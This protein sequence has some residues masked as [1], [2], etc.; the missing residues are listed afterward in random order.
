MKLPPREK[1]ALSGAGRR[2]LLWLA[3][4]SVL[5]Y[6]V[7]RTLIFLA[8]RSE[9]AFPSFIVMVVYAVLLLGFVLAYLIYNRFLYRKNVTIEQLPDDWTLEQKQA[10]LADGEERLAKS[11]WMMTI[12]FPL[13]L[14]FFL[15]ALDLFIFDFFK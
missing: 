12:I 1:K 7:Y 8:E 15:D 2:H 10:F 14:T 6:A 9:N 5:F 11:K 13:V 3:V 4:N